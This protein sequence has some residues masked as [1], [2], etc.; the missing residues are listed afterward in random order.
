VKLLEGGMIYVYSEKPSNS[1]LAL[2]EEFGATRLR[3]FDG[4]NFWRQGQKVKL[5]EGDSLICWGGTVPEIEGVK[6][7]NADI[8]DTHRGLWNKLMAAGLSGPLKTYSNPFQDDFIPRHLD[9]QGGEDFLDPKPKDADYWVQ[10]VNFINEFRIHSFQNRSIRAGVKVVREGMNAHPSIR[11]FETGWRV[12]YANF[13]STEHLRKL[14]HCVP[15]ALE[16]DFACVDIGETS[17]GGFL[18]LDVKFA[19]TLSDDTTKAAYFKAI[20]RWLDTEPE[21]KKLERVVPPGPYPNPIALKRQEDARRAVEVA[22]RNREVATMEGRAGRPAR[23]PVARPNRSGSSPPISG[24]YAPA[25][26]SDWM[27]EPIPPL[28]PMPVFTY[29][30]PTDLFDPEG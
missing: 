30:P 3:Q 12:E 23:V 7:L 25:P 9:R 28:E 1:A 22:R 24:R 13:S 11:T 19:P 5:K 29:T 26:P 16:L 2:C 17:T 10:K 8:P 6:I 20:K 21:V 27:I 18:I 15:R 4:L 14:A